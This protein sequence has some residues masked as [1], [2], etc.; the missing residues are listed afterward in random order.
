MKAQAQG[1]GS[2]TLA[3]MIKAARDKGMTYREL[4]RRSG[5]VVKAQTFNNIALGKHSLQFKDPAATAEAMATALGEPVARV[6]TA[7]GEGPGSELPPIPWP[8]RFN[9]LSPARRKLALQLLEDLLTA[10]EAENRQE[11]NARG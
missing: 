1:H 7:M 10:Q 8:E 5:G 2:M 11:K 4:E 3:E 6:R 9:R